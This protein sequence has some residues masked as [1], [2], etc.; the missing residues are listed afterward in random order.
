MNMNFNV[1][2]FVHNK[3]LVV[4]K[5]CQFRTAGMMCLIEIEVLARK[6]N[7]PFTL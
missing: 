2:D 3:K 4:C 1:E 7:Q 6:I 5:L